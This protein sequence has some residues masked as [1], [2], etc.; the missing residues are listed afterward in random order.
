MKLTDITVNALQP[1]E[2]GQKTYVDDALP[3]FGVRISSGGVKSFVVVHGRSR[4]RTTIGRYPV[5][6]LADAR[7][8]AKRVLAERTL[9]K[10]RMPTIA[11]Q[12]ALTLFLETHCDQNNR[13]GTKKETKRLLERHFLPSL[14]H[15][16]LDQFLFREGIID[17]LEMVASKMTDL[18]ALRLRTSAREMIMPRGLAAFFQVLV[19]K[20]HP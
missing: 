1:P 8:A 14:R 4:T 19:Q 3:G 13:P 10:H 5:V 12:E 17:E 16:R 9:G 20:K 2:Q 11:F 15:E 7:V 18:D 6:T